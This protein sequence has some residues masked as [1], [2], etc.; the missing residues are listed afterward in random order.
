MQVSGRPV[1]TLMSTRDG[2]CLSAADPAATMTAGMDELQH[3]L[4]CRNR[5]FY[6]YAQDGDDFLLPPSHPMR[7]KNTKSI[8]LCHSIWGNTDAAC[9]DSV[10][11]Q[12]V[13][14]SAVLEAFCNL[15]AQAL[16]EHHCTARPDA[17][18]MDT[19]H[20]SAISL[21]K[22]RRT[23]RGKRAG[24]H[25]R[26]NLCRRSKRR[27][28]CAASSQESS[29]SDCAAF[30]DSSAVTVGERLFQRTLRR[31]TKRKLSVVGDLSTQVLS[32]NTI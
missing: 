10:N 14:C 8:D 7:T 24:K 21:T 3:Y 12:T 28:L 5:M 1:T 25:V 20:D 29:G 13:V 2:H 27:R 30:F 4:I 16:L 22:H 32:A 23:R 31:T 9:R 15:N 6:H 26:D 18:E 19:S 11:A 17:V